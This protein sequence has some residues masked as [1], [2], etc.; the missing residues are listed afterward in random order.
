MK[1]IFKIMLS[2]LFTKC[3]LGCNKPGQ[4]ICFK[5]K[6]DKIK[7]NWVY[8]CHICNKE[9]CNAYSESHLECKEYTYLDGIFFL[10]MY[11]GMIKKAICEIKYSGY[12]SILYDLSKF[13]ADFLKLY[14]KKDDF[15]VTY[16]PMH[17]DKENSRG[18]NQ[19]K[20]LAKSLSKILKKDFTN[21]LEKVNSTENPVKLNK[22]DRLANLR[23]SFRFNKKNTN[24]PQIVIIIDDVYTTRSTLNE[25]ARILKNSGVEKVYG[26]VIAKAG[27][28]NQV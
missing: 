4:Y 10:T 15:V 12:Y 26:Y 8:V 23:N 22:Y 27:L 9:S 20:I 16:V 14:Y 28:I 13:M 11:E 25:C 21:L 1:I 3:C 24:I 19:S 17:T 5:C 6:R 7:F 2:I 18:F